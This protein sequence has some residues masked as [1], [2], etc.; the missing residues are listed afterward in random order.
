MGCRS[1]YGITQQ[2]RKSILSKIFKPPNKDVWSH[3]V[4]KKYFSH[5]IHDSLERRTREPAE[6]PLTV[7]VVT[8][9]DEKVLGVRGVVSA[10]ATRAFSEGDTPRGVDTDHASCALSRNRHEQNRWAVRW[11]FSQTEENM[12]NGN[13][14]FQLALE[15]EETPDDAESNVE[16]EADTAMTQQWRIAWLIHCTRSPLLESAHSQRKKDSASLM[17]CTLSCSGQNVTHHTTTP[18]YHDPLS[19]KPECATETPYIYVRPPNRKTI[20]IDMYNKEK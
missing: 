3:A 14:T 2:N 10:F 17:N 6:T 7:T 12:W 19:S 18:T 15:R 4:G 11:S 20:A 16:D 8:A 9:S 1:D 13:H 5:L